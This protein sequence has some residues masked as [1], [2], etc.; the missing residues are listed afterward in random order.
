MKIVNN[1]NFFYLFATNYIDNF[2]PSIMKIIFRVLPAT[3]AP[4]RR[5]ATR[6]TF[7]LKEKRFGI[8]LRIV[9]EFIVILSLTYIVMLRQNHVC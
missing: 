2:K 1:Y 6:T 3:I 9:D 7:I 4:R 5:A 8:Q